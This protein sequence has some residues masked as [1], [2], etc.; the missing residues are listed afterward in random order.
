MIPDCTYAS[1]IT[2]LVA[3]LLQRTN[4]SHKYRTEIGPGFSVRV[5]LFIY[6]LFLACYKANVLITNRYRHLLE[7]VASKTG[8]VLNTQYPPEDDRRH[9]QWE[10]HTWLH[11]HEPLICQCV[12][13]SHQR[14][15]T[16]Q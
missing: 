11:S 6:Y 9:F 8:I 15:I 13:P 7:N 16:S 10:C 5:Y 2:L 1:L 14:V 4:R 12:I 3:E